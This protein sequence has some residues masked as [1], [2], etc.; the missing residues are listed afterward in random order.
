MANGGESEKAVDAYCRALTL[1]PGFVRAR[2][3]LGI[4]CFNLRAYRQAVEHFLTALKQQNEGL[5][6]LGAHGQMSDN[7]WR[8]LGTA[9]S[10]LERP[11]LEI[12]IINRD[13]EKLLKEFEIN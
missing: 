10:H 9:L 4:S 2:Y 7:I 1:S 13:L 5:G 8:T 3:N 6:P 11:D 12:S